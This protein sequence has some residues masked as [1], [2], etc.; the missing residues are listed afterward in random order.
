MDNARG[1][2]PE[3]GRDQAVASGKPYV[4]TAVG[5]HPPAV[6]DDFLGDGVVSVTVADDRGAL[7][8][9]GSSRRDGEDVVLYE[10]GRDGAGKDVRTWRIGAH[11]GHFEA[12]ERAIF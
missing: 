9:I 8:I 6:L 12:V 10:K 5:D 1:P 11:D 3:V 7:V 4:V 2:R